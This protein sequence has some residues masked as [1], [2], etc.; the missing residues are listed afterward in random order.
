MSSSAKKGKAARLRSGTPAGSDAE[1]A[2]PGG[3]HICVPADLCPVRPFL[4]YM[5]LCWLTADA[6]PDPSQSPAATACPADEES[7]DKALLR[8]LQTAP[9]GADAPDMA[10]AGEPLLEVHMLV[11]FQGPSVFTAH[12]WLGTAALFEDCLL[13]QSAAVTSLSKIPAQRRAAMSNH[14]PKTAACV[15]CSPSAVLPRV[16]WQAPQEQP[17]HPN[18]SAGHLSQQGRLSA[19]PPGH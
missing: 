1:A 5:S 6:I 9:P 8:K 19:A 17:L 11:V 7:W 10:P 4:R 14:P 2:I 16:V 13:R 3:L 12:A 18:W 15:S